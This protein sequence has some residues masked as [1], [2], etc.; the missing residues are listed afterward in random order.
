MSPLVVAVQRR[1]RILLLP[2][3]PECARDVPAGPELTEEH[4]VQAG[5]LV[6][7]GAVP[8]LLRHLL[9]PEQCCSSTK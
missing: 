4:L 7:L 5:A 2:A 9:E 3:T 8:R 6:V 1:L